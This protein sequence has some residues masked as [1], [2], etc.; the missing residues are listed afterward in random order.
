MKAVEI[1]PGM[2]LPVGASKTPDGRN[3]ISADE[4]KR[5]DLAQNLNENID[6]LEDILKRRPEL[7]GPVAGRW[8][9]VRSVA[10]T[11]DPDVS[12]LMTIEHQLGMVAQGAHGMRSAQGV[13][14]AARSLTNGFHNSPT[15]TK[16]ALEAARK[17]VGTFLGDSQKPGQARTATA[18]PAGGD[19]PAHSLATAMALPFN[20]GKSADQVR[21]D[22]VSRGYRVV[23]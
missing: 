9:Q 6:T 8:T 22:L 5:A 3:K 16:A 1:T 23:P 15:A 17:S 19:G 11:D 21:A 18:S 4:Q 14:S 13:E 10:G 7:F 12:Q 2:T 20:K